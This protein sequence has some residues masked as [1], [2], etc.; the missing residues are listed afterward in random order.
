MFGRKFGG[1]EG[2]IFKSRGKGNDWP[3]LAPK[4]GNH[5]LFNFFGKEMGEGQPLNCK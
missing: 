5:A 2:Y 4:I 3:H 1:E